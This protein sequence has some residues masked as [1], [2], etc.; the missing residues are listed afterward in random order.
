[1]GKIQL[2]LLMFL[3][4]PI[5]LLAQPKQHSQPK[6]LVFTNVTVIDDTGAPAKP[7]MTVVITGNRF[8]APGKRGTVRVLILK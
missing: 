6:P 7:N 4:Q 8:T 2:S 1:M 5:L 3:L